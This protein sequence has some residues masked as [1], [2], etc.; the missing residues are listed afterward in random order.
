M[1]IN[2][3]KDNRNSWYS[4]IVNQKRNY[5]I[6]NMLKDNKIRRLS[7]RII[8]KKKKKINKKTKKISIFKSIYNN[9]FIYL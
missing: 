6:L 1:I 8:S 4:K 5:E 2:P 9:I 7:H 3:T